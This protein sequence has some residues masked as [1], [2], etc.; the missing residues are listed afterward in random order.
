MVALPPIVKGTRT[1]TGNERLRLTLTCTAVPSEAVCAVEAKLRV[2][3]REE[4]TESSFNEPV[5]VP[6]VSRMSSKIPEG[7]PVREVAPI[8]RTLREFSPLKI[9]AGIDVRGLPAKSSCSSLL[10]PL[11]IEAGRLVRELLLRCSIVRLFSPLKTPE[12]KLPRALLLNPTRFRLLNPLKIPPAR[13]VSLLWNR[14]RNCRELRLL[15]VASDKAL[16]EL[17]RRSSSCRLLS[18][19]KIPAGRLVRELL[20]SFNSVSLVSPPK[21][22][23]LRELMEELETIRRVTPCRCVEVTFPHPETPVSSSN[24]SRT[25]DVRS[26]IPCAIARDCVIRTTAATPERSRGIFRKRSVLMSRE[27]TA[28]TLSLQM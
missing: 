2:A 16:S 23:A 12:G 8:C 26:Q 6:R 9:E 18:P 27:V 13:V 25:W 20:S 1:A 5:S 3:F 19:L 11:K 22:P 10:S 7:K 28:I 24:L 17:D 15:N 21:S 14:N 4:S